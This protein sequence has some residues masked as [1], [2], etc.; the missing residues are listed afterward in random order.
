MKFSDFDRRAW[1][2][3]GQYYDTCIIPYSG[4]QGTENPPETATLLERQR[5]FLE[6]AEQPYK[7]RVVTY[8]AV[9]YAGPGMTAIVNE[10]CRKVKSSGFQYVIV[11]SANEGL[12][13]ED[14]FESDL[15]LCLTEIM[16][17]SRASV[18]AYVRSE[19]QALWQNGK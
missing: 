7:G 5:D 16:S 17:D 15:L 8:P 12:R 10:L 14:V 19:I 1:E 4:L 3:D 2:I 11:M 13:K 9:Q 6:L 18:S